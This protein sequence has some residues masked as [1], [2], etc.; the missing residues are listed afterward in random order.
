MYTDIGTEGGSND[1][2][3]YNRSVLKEALQT[4]QLNLPAIPENDPLE[5]P[6]HLIGDDAFSLPETM[7]KPYPHKSLDP[8]ERIFNYRFSHA[9]WCVENAFGI[10]ASRYPTNQKTSHFNLFSGLI[11]SRAI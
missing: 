5:V 1:S 3:I 6:F 8:Q 9:R 11:Y 10:M 2:G 4:G 7:M